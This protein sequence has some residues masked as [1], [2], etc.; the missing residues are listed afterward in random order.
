MNTFTIEEAKK[1]IADKLGV[2]EN[3]VMITRGLTPIKPGKSLIEKLDKLMIQF[4]DDLGF[5]PDKRILAIK[6]FHGNF[7]NFFSDGH[8][9][10]NLTP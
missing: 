6:S 2:N 4:Q 3:E 8:A 10:G 1:F 7:P 9:K 5:S